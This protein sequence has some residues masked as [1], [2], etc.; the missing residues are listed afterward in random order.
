MALT[1]TADGRKK[2]ALIVFKEG[3]KA[4][5]PPRVLAALRVPANV[6]VTASTNGWMTGEKMAS[7]INRIW[8][9]NQ[10]D[11]R[12]L[13]VLDQ[14]RIHTMQATRDRYHI[15]TFFLLINLLF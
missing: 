8:G 13:L 11:V 1:A 2:P 14:A 10:D 7:W 12:R 4:A 15:H 9:P 6:K 3:R 5:I